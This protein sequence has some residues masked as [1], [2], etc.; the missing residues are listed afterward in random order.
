MALGFAST[1]APQAYNPCMRRPAKFTVIGV[2]TDVVSSKF[3]DHLPYSS[4]HR[5]HLPP[6]SF[7]TK[8]IRSI[9]RGIPL[10][11]FSPP[12]SL[13]IYRVS[14]VNLS[15][16]LYPRVPLSSL[17]PFLGEHRDR[18]LRNPIRGS[19][20]RERR[21]GSEPLPTSEETWIVGKFCF[22]H[23]P[24][25]ATLSSVSRARCREAITGLDVYFEMRICEAR[26]PLQI[27]AVK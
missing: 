3:F 11:C 21:L 25:C 23:P 20:S 15:L 10:I 22:S 8:S 12:S 26:S 4:S 2:A 19:I 27:C 18:G 6:I 7:Q 24:P 14:P 9:L 16:S 17:A 1:L 5:L 13:Q